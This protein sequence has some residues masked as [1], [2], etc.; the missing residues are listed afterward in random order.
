RFQLS[1]LLNSPSLSL[2]EREIARLW[3]YLFPHLNDVHSESGQPLEIIFP[4]YVNKF[5]GP[6]LRAV[7]IKLGRIE[8]EGAVEIH[9]QPA[10][11]YQHAHHKD[12]AYNS[13]ILHLCLLSAGDCPTR[14]ED[15]KFIP[16]VVMDR[17]LPEIYAEFKDD[18][19]S[20]TSRLVSVK[21]PCFRSFRAKKNKEFSRILEKIGNCWLMK[22]AAAFN[23]IPKSGRLW[24]SLVEALGYTANHSAFRYLARRLGAKRFYQQIEAADSGLELES[25]L[26]GV[27]G[28][29]ERPF[30]GK[31][32]RTVYRRRKLWENNFPGKQALVK[33]QNWNRRAVRPHCYPLRRWIAFGRASRCLGEK[34]KTWLE[35]Q[36][37]ITAGEKFR[38]LF[39]AKL[40]DYFS[41]PARNYWKFHY[42][43]SDCRHKSVPAPVGETW[44]DQV[45]VN[46]ILPW[47][48]FRALAGKTAYRC[49]EV[50]DILKSY[51]PVL[52]NRR[53]KKI[54]EQSGNN[55]F[56]WKNISQQQGAVFLYKKFCRAGNCESCPL[57]KKT[58]SLEFTGVTGR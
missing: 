17:Y 46:V 27:G 12:P 32:N 50:E 19:H 30:S 45:I 49:R 18:F 10:D 8:R 57:A 54:K 47:L 34:W 51:P 14:R 43:C 1:L 48:Y 37:I 36:P 58:D 55:D 41:L 33:T 15:N 22:R 29:L 24:Q 25:W 28:W 44:F 42:T 21:H 2:T 56:Q 5:S 38:R 11:W 9:R 26:L 39:T 13:V 7:K 4:G 53:T 6:D 23:K 20:V 40:S 35:K 16:L 3:K 31:I 52:N